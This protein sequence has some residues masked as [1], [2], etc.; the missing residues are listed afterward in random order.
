MTSLFFFYVIRHGK[1]NHLRCFV[2][3]AQPC[4]PRSP[5]P[6]T[7]GCLSGCLRMRTTVTAH[8]PLAL[9]PAAGRQHADVSK[10]R[11]P[12]GSPESVCVISAGRHR[13]ADL[14]RCRPPAKASLQEGGLHVAYKLG[15]HH[16]FEGGRAVGGRQVLGPL[17]GF[18]AGLHGHHVEVHIGRLFQHHG[19]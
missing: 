14:P 19:V 13:N 8:Q 17:R 4:P 5:S 15:V 2:K 11:L 16:L 7:S 18:V 6:Q 10:K 12:I 1:C 9:A 3:H